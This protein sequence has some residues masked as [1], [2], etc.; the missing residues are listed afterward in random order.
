MIDPSTDGWPML[1][2]MLLGRLDVVH[3]RFNIRFLLID[4]MIP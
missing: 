3:V 2:Y 4:F 1:N